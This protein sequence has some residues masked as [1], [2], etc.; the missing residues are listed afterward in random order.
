MARPEDA[1]R[2]AIVHLDTC[3]YCPWIITGHAAYLKH[4]AQ[5]HPQGERR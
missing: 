1:L 4:L 3:D 2:D 5:D